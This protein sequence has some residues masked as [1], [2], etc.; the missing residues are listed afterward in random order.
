MDKP[1]TIAVEVVKEL[2]KAMEKFPKFNSAHE[3]Y[4]VLLE[5]VDEAW[6][7]IKRNDL[8]HARKEMIQV[9]AMAIR[10]LHD[11]YKTK[12]EVRAEIRH[13]SECGISP[14]DVERAEWQKV[15]FRDGQVLILKYMGGYGDATER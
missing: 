7:A 1:T 6:D 8:D 14:T 13:M 12:D 11:L 3:G 4:A 9:A 10:F 2:N 5:E 15:I